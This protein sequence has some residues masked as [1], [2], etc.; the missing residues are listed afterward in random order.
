MRLCDECVIESICK[1]K[2]IHEQYTSIGMGYSCWSFIK[3]G[4]ENEQ[5]S[6]QN[7][8]SEP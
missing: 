7:D 8:G 6:V 1:I 5:N 4:D 2:G 3:K